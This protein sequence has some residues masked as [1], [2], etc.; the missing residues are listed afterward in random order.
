M[1][2]GSYD[3]G[4]TLVDIVCLFCVPN[5]VKSIPV[6]FLPDNLSRRREPVVEE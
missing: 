6:L 3:V 1:N 4:A 2:V 5:F